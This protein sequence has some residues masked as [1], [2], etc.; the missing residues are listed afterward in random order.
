MV[1][2][3]IC[4]KNAAKNNLI[5]ITIL[6]LCSLAFLLL[7]YLSYHRVDK[8][9]S[10]L[11]G[12]QIR[13][14]VVDAGHGG[15]DGGASGKSKILEKDIN[16]QISLDLQKLLQTA[17]YHV[18]MT[19]TSDTAVSD[20]KSTIRERKKSDLHNRLA[21]I[22]SQENCIFISIHQNFF[23][24]SRY[25]GSQ[26][27]YSKKNPGSKLMAESV[28][29][30]IVSLLQNDNKREIKPATS[31][32]YL[33]WKTDIPAILVECGF[34]S[35]SEE[36]AKLNNSTYQQQMAFSIFCGALDYISNLS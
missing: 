3:V 34:L 32:I 6:I 36:E 15:E 21:I 17:G 4:L 13:T 30:R 14:I 11:A 8:M 22:Q 35:N 24:Q 26:V 10:T 12:Q 20:D 29:T 2:E 9:A 27:F 7:S 19:R 25:H 18:V 33:L 23:S 5:P 28:R 1:H 16:L 31:S